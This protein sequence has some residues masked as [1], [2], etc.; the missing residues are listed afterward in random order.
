MW[1]EARF[2]TVDFDKADWTLTEKGLFHKGFPAAV[3]CKA[4]LLL[5]PH[6]WIDQ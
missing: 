6:R 1:T 2:A 4:D 3:A 5:A